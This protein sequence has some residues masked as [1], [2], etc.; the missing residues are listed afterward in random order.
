MAFPDAAVAFIR[1]GEDVWREL[2]E[3]VLRVQVHP[4]QVVHPRNLLVGVHRG[5][6]AADISLRI[7]EKVLSAEILSVYTSKS[8]AALLCD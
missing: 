2:P 3:M 6:D 5:Q 1:Y 4:L 7:M 8:E